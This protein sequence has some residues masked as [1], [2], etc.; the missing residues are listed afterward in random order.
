MHVRDH[1]YCWDTSL[2]DGCDQRKNS[3]GTLEYLLSGDFSDLVAPAAVA[4]AAAPAAQPKGKAW[5]VPIEL[6]RLFAYMQLAD[7][8]GTSTEALT[9]AFGWHGHEERIQHDIHELNR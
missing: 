7:Q 4:A 8:S 5:K 1:I 9:K 2:T 3:E 6:R